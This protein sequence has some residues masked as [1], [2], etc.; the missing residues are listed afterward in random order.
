[1]GTTQNSFTR[2]AGMGENSTSQKSILPRQV[3]KNGELARDQPIDRRLSNIA[4]S[5]SGFYREPTISEH[6]RLRST[7]ESN[8]AQNIMPDSQRR[9]QK[10]DQTQ[11]KH[12]PNLNFNQEEQ[13]LI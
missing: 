2:G 6:S 4:N 10:N 3:G 9:H 5:V 7:H 8:F 11:F 12:N 13:K 1:M